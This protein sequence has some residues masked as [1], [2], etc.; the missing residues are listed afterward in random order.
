MTQILRECGRLT[1]QYDNPNY[2]VSH[3]PLVWPFRFR[4]KGPLDPKENAHNPE[5]LKNEVDSKRMGN[6]SLTMALPI[7]NVA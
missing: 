5:K 7:G 6:T 3:L 1:I 4:P 2:R